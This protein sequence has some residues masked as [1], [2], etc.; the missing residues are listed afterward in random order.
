MSGFLSPDDVEWEQRESNA[1]Y[2]KSELY[3]VYLLKAVDLHLMKAGEKLDITLEPSSFEI[4]MIS[5]VLEYG[6]KIK[7]AGV[8]LENML[9]SGGAIELV[10]ERIGE[11]NVGYAVKIKGVGKFLAYSSVKPEKVKLDEESVGFE[12]RDDGVL[13]FEVPW[14]GGEVKDAQILF[15]K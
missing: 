8:G 3:V 11:K 5:P 14:N 15:T 4:T 13:K 7:F 2:R 1:D 10:E 9:N 12:W 6:E